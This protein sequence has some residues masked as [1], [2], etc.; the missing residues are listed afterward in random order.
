M[1]DKEDMLGKIPKSSNEHASLNQSEAIFVK[2][3]K[4]PQ[5]LPEKK[6]SMSLSD[7]NTSSQVIP[8]EP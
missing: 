3:E 8:G 1:V 6:A 7:F 4:V 2:K 5:I